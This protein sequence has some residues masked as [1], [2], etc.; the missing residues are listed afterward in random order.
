MKKFGGIVQNW[1]LHTLSKELRKK[2]NVL[3][4]DNIGKILTG[5]FT[6][7]PTGRWKVG[8][9]MRS[10]LVVSFDGL[11]VETLN[12]RYKVIGP[13]WGNDMGDSVLGIYF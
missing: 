4:P 8:D 13:A 10:S 5:T 3:Y 12:T 6:E 2:Y 9:F 7:E 11:T 1:H